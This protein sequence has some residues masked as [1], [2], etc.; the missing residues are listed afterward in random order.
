MEQTLRSLLTDT[1][2]M[3]SRLDLSALS[4]DELFEHLTCKEDIDE[5]I[6]AHLRTQNVTGQDFLELTTEELKTLPNLTLGYKK[7]LERIQKKYTSNPT[8][9]IACYI[10]HS[11]DLKSMLFTNFLDAVSVS[12]LSYPSMPQV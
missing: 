8:V 7:A 9:R 5:S 3:D 10:L 1:S 4:V 6:A 12:A 11:L 2:S